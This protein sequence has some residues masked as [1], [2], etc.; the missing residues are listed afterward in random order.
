MLVVIESTL[1]LPIHH[2][3]VHERMAKRGRKV[4]KVSDLQAVQPTTVGS[5]PQFP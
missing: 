3:N 1:H 5:V 4:P 2:A